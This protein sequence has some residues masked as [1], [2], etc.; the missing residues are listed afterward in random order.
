[1]AL[2]T[3]QIKQR[4]S[5]TPPNQ[6]DNEAQ[7]IINNAAKIE[8][9]NLDSEGVL[10]LYEA[11][12][13]LPPRYFSSNDRSALIK[14]KN[15]TQYQP[16]SANLAEVIKLINRVKPSP[17]FAQVTPAF[18]NRIYIAENKRLSRLERMGFDG[19]TIGRGQLGQPAYTDV[20][21]PS[22]FKGIFEEYINRVF[23]PELLKTEFTTHQHHWNF[24]AYSTNIQPGY[25]SI[26]RNKKLEDFVVTAYMAIRI[27]SATKASRSVKDTA[28]FAVAL[29][30]GMRNMVVAAQKSTGNNIDWSPIEVTLRNQGHTDEADYVNEVVI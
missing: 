7:K 18:I 19:S 20:I 16:V 24:G 2:T 12:A 22:G 21:S 25:S 8:L 30:H 15:N 1:M 5:N 3:S 29:Y 14:L 6:K 10:R 9:K 26:Y 17:Q 28:K 13:M 11:L 23:I 27:N 4:L